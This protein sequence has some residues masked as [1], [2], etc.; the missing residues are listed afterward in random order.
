MIVHASPLLRIGMAAPQALHRFDG[1]VTPEAVADLTGF[2]DANAGR[3]VLLVINSPGGD[4][5]AGG[6]AGAEIERHGRVTALGQGVVA[7]AATCLFLAAKRRVLHRTCMSMIHDPQT[8]AGG[9][10]DDLSKVAA[11]LETFA[12]M[13]ADTYARQT[14]HPPARVRAWMKA[15]TWMTAEEAVALNFADAVETRGE[16]EVPAEYDYSLYQNTPTALRRR[17]AEPQGEYS[18]A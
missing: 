10:P 12:Q 4:A 16:G 13:H 3:H 1:G 14:G 2:L 15:E 18:D 7:S 17:A 8:L 5:M 11:D 6:A 9:T